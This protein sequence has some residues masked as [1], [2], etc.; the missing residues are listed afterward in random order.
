MSTE[1]PPDAGS[2]ADPAAPIDTGP[3]K[4][5]PTVLQIEAIECGAASLAMVLAGFGGWVSLRELREACHISRDGTSLANVMEAAE[6]YGLA[7]EG[8]RGTAR[9]LADLPMPAIIWWQ[10]N[11]YVVLEGAHGGTFHVNDPARGRMTYPQEYFAENYS[12]AAVTF[13]TTPD[14]SPGGKPFR[15]LPSLLSRLP[16]VRGGVLLAFLAGLLALLPGLLI[17][18]VSSLFVNGVLGEG[19]REFLPFLIGTLA[20]VALLRV[21]LTLVEYRSLAKVQEKL[22]SRSS[23]EFL[24]RLLRV[25]IPF[26]GSRNIGDLVQRVGYNSAI[27][28]LLASQVAGAIISLVAII[29]YAALMFYYSWTLAL[30]VLALAACNVVVLR[31]VVRRRT[32]GQGLVMVDQGHLQAT[33]V[34]SLQSIETIKA[35]GLEPEV[36]AKWTDQQT[37]MVSSEASFVTPTA[38]VSAV[39]VTLTMLTSAAILVVGALE[40]I[41]GHLTLGGLLAFQ[42][43]TAGVSAPIT[44]LVGAASQVQ[45]ITVDLQRLDDALDNPLD[46]R[47]AAASPADATP[48]IAAAAER[49]I[50]GAVS[51]TDVMFGYAEGQPPLIAGFNLDLAPGHRVALVGASGSGKTTI[52]NLAAGLLTPWSGTITYD[53]RAIT[54]IDPV[55]LSEQMAKVDQTIMLFAGSVRDNITLWDPTIDDETVTRALADA[56]I[57]DEVLARPGGLDGQIIEGGMNFSGGERQRLEI[58]R[59]LVRSPNFLILDEATS[60][61]DTATE[62]AVDAAIRARGCTCMIIAHRLSTIRDADEIIML[63]RGGRV[64]ERGTHDELMA[65]GGPYA[66]LVASAGGGGD[67]GS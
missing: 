44:M 32:V 46:P 56:Q 18:P 60:A 33:T 13:A 62:A 38:V 67:V 59:S 35:G 5:V 63:A 8:H 61:L 25:P 57:L 10:R 17:A 41:N 20:L 54:E 14:F 19:V 6:Q 65:A 52:G 4:K 7:P 39:P 24:V 64:V 42:S 27:A 2:A 49:P 66:E 15:S 51:F 55:V 23:V 47:F 3:R 53:G 29:A 16:G 1:T 58:A 9:D 48:E 12:G 40:V 50:T 21:G 34:S 43:L 45:T 31:A 37:R 28:Q 11:H 26:F 36:F 22:A 30:I